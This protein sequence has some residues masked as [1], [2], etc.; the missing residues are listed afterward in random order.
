MTDLELEALR[1]DIESDRVERKQSLSDKDKIRQAMCA[2]ANDLPNHQA[3]RRA[4][5]RR[6]RRRILRGIADHR[7]VAAYLGPHAV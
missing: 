1:T 5:R 3:S 2:F 6:K 7:R 4:I